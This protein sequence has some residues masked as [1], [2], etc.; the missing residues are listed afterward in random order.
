MLCRTIESSFIYLFSARGNS[1]PSRKNNLGP[2]SRILLCI[3]CLQE[4]KVMPL[5]GQLDLIK[6]NKPSNN[7]PLVP[8]LLP[9][10]KSLCPLLQLHT[11]NRM[12]KLPRTVSSVD[13]RG[14][15]NKAYLHYDAQQ[16]LCLVSPLFP[17]LLY[18]QQD[19]LEQH[20]WEDWL[21]QWRSLGRIHLLVTCREELNFSDLK[22]KK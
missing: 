21:K 5:Q 7:C 6:T 18:H 14:S 8:Q 4:H 13:T 3:S 16:S 12:F 11:Q 17:S 19:L 2:F 20:L 10:M 9:T 22:V 15:G 1:N